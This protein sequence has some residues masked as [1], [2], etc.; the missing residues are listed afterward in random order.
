[1]SASESAFDKLIMN[2]TRRSFCLLLISQPHLPL[3]HAWLAIGIRN[4]QRCTVRRWNFV[5]D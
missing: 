1:M 4:D 2:E 3:A 5:S